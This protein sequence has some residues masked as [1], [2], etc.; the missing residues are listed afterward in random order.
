LLRREDV[1]G[2]G[3]LLTTTKLTTEISTA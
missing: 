2:P 3:G 1:C